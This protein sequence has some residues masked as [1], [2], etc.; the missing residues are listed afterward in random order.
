[1]ERKWCEETVEN[2]WRDW[3]HFSKRRFRTALSLYAQKNSVWFWSI[4]KE[5]LQ[6]SRMGPVLPTPVLSHAKINFYWSSDIEVLSLLSK[7]LVKIK[8]SEVFIVYDDTQKLS[9]WK[10][11]W[12]R[13]FRGRKLMKLE[14]C[15]CTLNMSFP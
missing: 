10:L 2:D 13:S 5:L 1:M 14:I 4:K 6:F 12:E 15:D 8:G 9:F 11:F 3:W 7:L